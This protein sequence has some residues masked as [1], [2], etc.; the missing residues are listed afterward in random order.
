M[1]YRVDDQVLAQYVDDGL[2]YPAQI[3]GITPLGTYWL[4]FTDYGNEQECHED[5]IL[6]FAGNIEILPQ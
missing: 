5:Q 4:S 2:W 1:K 6:P 3:K